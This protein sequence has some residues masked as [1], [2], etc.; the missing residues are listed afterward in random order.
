VREI[1]RGKR[2]GAGRAASESEMGGERRARRRKKRSEWGR[3]ETGRARE[4]VSAV[5]RGSVRV[6]RVLSGSR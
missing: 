5:E 6:I 1:K 3:A 2:D 4:G